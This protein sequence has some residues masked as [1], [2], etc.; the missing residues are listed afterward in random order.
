MTENIFDTHI[1]EK[2][3]KDVFVNKSISMYFFSLGLVLY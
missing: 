3:E 1:G 2:E